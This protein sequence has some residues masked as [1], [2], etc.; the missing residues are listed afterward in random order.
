MLKNY[1]N[2]LNKILKV[3]KIKFVSKQFFSQKR[4]ID[5]MRSVFGI[6]YFM[7]KHV[8]RLLGYS[9]NIKVHFVSD[10]QK[11]LISDFL[12]SYLL[13]ERGLKKF[14]NNILIT[15]KDNG[16]IGGYRLFK[17]L[18]VNGQRTHTNSKTVRKLFK[19]YDFSDV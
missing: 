11:N 19:F 9:Y 1:K 3:K 18:P 16:S 2:S 14:R 10:F 6:N 7:G 17:G 13:I 5:C 4:F 15:R 8:L 12:L